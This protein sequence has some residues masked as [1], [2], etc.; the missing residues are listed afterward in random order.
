MVTYAETSAL[1]QPAG[2]GR[3]AALDRSHTHRSGIS[4][5]AIFAGAA[6]AAALSLIL[7]LLGTGLGF[8]AM[9]PWADH[10]ASATTLG[11]SS[12][13]WLALTQI[14][15]AGMGGY[16]AGRLRSRWVNTHG[17]E[18]Y[19][20]DTAHGFLSW[21][22]ATLVTVA[23]V[24]GSASAVVSGGAKAGAAVAAGGAS[25]A[26]AAAANSSDPY[27]YFIDALFR[28]TRPVAV[29]DDAAHGVVG[30]IIARTISNGGQLAADDR[31]YLAQ[32]VTQRTSLTQAQ[33]EQRVDQVYG[34]AR[35]SVEDAKVAAQKA[36]DQAAKVAATASLWMFVALLCGA[37]FASF[38][39]IYGGR[40]RDAV[41]YVETEHHRASAL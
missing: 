9:S 27:G 37:F 3:D 41:V 32:M 40:R 23:L 11:V 30:R 18:V 35:Q 1:T 38:A 12:I 6:G 7:I 8:S 17:D 20:R 26:G 4:W 36:A 34:Q 14:I 39:A 29:S 22:V 33:A 5:A 25:V 24:V 13:V 31:A 16:L 15:A 10:G 2:L 21:A 28:D 19:F